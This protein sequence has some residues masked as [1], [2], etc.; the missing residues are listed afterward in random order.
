MPDAIVHRLNREIGAALADP[1]LAAAFESHGSLPYHASPAAFA[2]RIADDRTLWT[3]L[4]Q[5]I[6]VKA[7]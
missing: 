5:R 1:A 2:Q 6:G 7:D 4:L 3:P